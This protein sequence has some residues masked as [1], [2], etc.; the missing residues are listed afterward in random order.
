MTWQAAS[1]VLLAVAVAAG[2]A[3]YE[4]DRPP[5]RVLAL[6]AAL[7][8]LAVVGRLA[9][10][11]VPNVKPT[12][13]IVLFAGFALGAL[14]GFAVGAVTA[15]VSNIFL[16]QGPWTVW[17]MAGWGAV[18]VGGALLARI[19]RG[20]EPSRLVLAAACGLAGLA[21]GAWM[22]VY[23]WT[24]GA[25]QDLD[26]YLVVAASSLPYNLAHAMGNVVF[27]LLIGPAFVRAL[28]RYRRRLEVRWPAPAGA[29]AG[30]LLLAVT[31]A[32]FALPQP[33]LA[34]TTADRAERYLLRAQNPDGGFGAAPGQSSSPLYTGWTGLGLA[35]AGRN[36]VDVERRGGR[37]IVG[38]VRRARGR[39]D[40]GEVERTVL[41]LRSAGIDPR[42]FGGRNLLAAIERRRRADGSIAGFVSYTAFGIL[43]LRASGEPA[44]AATVAWLVRNQNGDG[45]FGVATSSGSDADMTGAA[46]QALA[47]VRRGRGAAARRALG[48][49]RSAQNGDGGFGQM[50]GRS[51][52][53]QSTAYAVQGLVA[54][55]ARSRAAGRALAYLRGLARRDGSIAYSRTSSQTPVW[56]TAQALMA[57]RR[58]A[59]PIGAV[60]RAPRGRR[61]PKPAAAAATPAHPDGRSRVGAGEPRTAERPPKENEPKS[62][63]SGRLGEPAAGPGAARDTAFAIDPAP[64][65]RRAAAAA[66]PTGGGDAGPSP[67][68]F[69]VLLGALLAAALAVWRRRRLSR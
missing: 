25:R 8:A 40:I 50:P 51:S 49:L 13:D 17:Q 37:S 60:A 63:A 18:G 26:S 69:A 11:A 47:A 57:L 46:L 33:A 16:S 9:F 6:V 55:G 61:S 31:I 66:A 38:F 59:L 5:S 29:A 19:L 39:A 27:C 4:R 1:F 3:W 45:G 52:N 68:L 7:A 32:G 43:A 2:F 35:A 44:G 34:A 56:V 54:V 36:P 23:Q 28:E 62:S 42:R 20:R 58:T 24:L 41:L 64:A 65:S 21:F 53:A 67:L 48:W 10:A 14:P 22:D 12:T 30:C 15:I